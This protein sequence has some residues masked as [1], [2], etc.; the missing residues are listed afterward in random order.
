MLRELAIHQCSQQAVESRER[1]IIEIGGN[2]VPK[3]LVEKLKQPLRARLV[4]I[5]TGMLRF[6]FS[7]SPL[8]QK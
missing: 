4:S 6:T 3:D 5:T 1:L 2:K 8:S 7:L